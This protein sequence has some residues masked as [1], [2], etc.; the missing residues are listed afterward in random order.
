MERARCVTVSLPMSTEF[1]DTHHKIA[2]TL[3]FMQFALWTGS[4]LYVS[5]VVDHMAWEES[6]LQ[7]RW[8]RCERETERI[9][10]DGETCISS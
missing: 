9:T 2:N 3:I 4:C 5:T 10:H 6:N 7:S 8:G 1:T